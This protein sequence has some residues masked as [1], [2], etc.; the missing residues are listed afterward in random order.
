MTTAELDYRVEMRLAIGRVR[1]FAAITTTDL[2]PEL[3]RA[4]WLAIPA[5]RFPYLSDEMLAKQARLD[6][7]AA[8]EYG[9]YH[10]FSA[11]R[12]EDEAEFIIGMHMAGAECAKGQE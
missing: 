2:E 1:G 3:A 6:L 11:E 5:L 7:N 10:G 8:Y 9:G 12:I 4:V